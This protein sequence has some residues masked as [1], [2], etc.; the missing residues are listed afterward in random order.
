MSDVSAHYDRKQ[1]EQSS[2]RISACQTR[3]LSQSF[4]KTHAETVQSLVEWV[5]AATASEEAGAQMAVRN[6]GNVEFSGMLLVS[7]GGKH[8]RSEVY[9]L[10]E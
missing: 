9:S 4:G 5:W 8:P 6:T 10:N 1:E 2:R 3:T 7:D